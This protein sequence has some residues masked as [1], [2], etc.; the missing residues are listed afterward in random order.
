M[1][2]WGSAQ[3]FPLPMATIVVRSGQ[4]KEDLEVLEDEPRDL[5]HSLSERHRPSNDPAQS[6][7]HRWDGEAQGGKGSFQTSHSNRVGPHPKFLVSQFGVIST[8]PRCLLI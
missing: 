8:H 4:K 7:L 1:V 2:N 5:R 6:P 3:S